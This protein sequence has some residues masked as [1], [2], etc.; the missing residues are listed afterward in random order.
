MDWATEENVV[1]LA[2]RISPHLP[3]LRRFA[4]ALTGDEK[5]GDASVRRTLQA[6][7]EGRISLSSD[8]SPRIA[9]YRGFHQALDFAGALQES[10]THSPNPTGQR[11][12]RIPFRARELFLLTAMESFSLEDAGAVLGADRVEV[13]QLAADWRNAIDAELATRVL[14]IEDEPVIAAD[15]SACVREMGSEV[16]GIAKTQT[17][18]LAAADVVTPGIIL[19]DIQLADGSSGID[20]VRKILQ[21]HTA[22]IPVIFVTAFPERLL[23]G[24]RLEPTY[25]VTKPFHPSTLKAAIEQAL[26]FSG[27]ALSEAE[28]DLP[29]TTKESPATASAPLPTVVD[30][31]MTAAFRPSRSIISVEVENGRLSLLDLSPDS[32]I[33]T[34]DLEALRRHAL[35]IAIRVAE[36]PEGHNHPGLSSRIA[37]LQEGLS[38]PFTR[39]N[40]ILFCLEAHAFE[41]VRLRLDSLLTDDFAADLEALSD[42]L[43]KL[44]LRFENWVDQLAIA[45]T[46]RALDADTRAALVEVS[47]HLERQSDD[48]VDPHL[49]DILAGLRRAFETSSDKLSATVFVHV[50]SECLKAIA[51]WL[52]ERLLGMGNEINKAVEKAGT[53]VI[54]VSV[55][56]IPLGLMAANDP[57]VFHFVRE[58]LSLIESYL[59]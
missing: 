29:E 45:P 1:S 19:A 35:A 58:L 2:A 38:H 24:E 48:V 51:R 10:G 54:I 32:D 6:I 17:E 22:R 44:S 41:I 27:L 40:S 18:A 55:S 11:L 12:A 53:M 50:V 3:Y 9:L 20:A 30:E 13:D 26:F 59:K 57:E 5:S 16:I 8:L 34:S 15:I 56:S 33:A 21:R 4:R 49:R 42:E 37:D 47:Q 28:I 7:T 14:I 43:N 52:K 36:R 39:A 25:L 23:T 31:E 46:T